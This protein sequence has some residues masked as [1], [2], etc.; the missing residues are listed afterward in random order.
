[1]MWICVLAVLFLH[2]HD[3]WTMVNVTVLA[4]NLQTAD[5]V[6]TPDDHA[7]SSRPVTVDDLQKITEAMGAMQN[8]IRQNEQKIEDRISKLSQ[9]MKS[10]E[11]IGEQIKSMRREIVQNL[12]QK[13]NVSIFLH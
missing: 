11:N 8:A 4:P 7:A 2:C 12:I 5:S 1:M 9:Q 10:Q 3:G 6:G 13:T